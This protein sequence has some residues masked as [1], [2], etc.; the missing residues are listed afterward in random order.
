MNTL[1]ALTDGSQGREPQ[2]HRVAEACPERQRDGVVGGAGGGNAS[3]MKHVLVLGPA[4]QNHKRVVRVRIKC[5]EKA[6][7]VT[8]RWKR[9]VDLRT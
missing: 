7:M 6:I 8:D 3:V 1:S 5:G 2:L 4:A 9:R